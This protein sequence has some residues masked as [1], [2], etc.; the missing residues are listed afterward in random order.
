MEGDAR[1]GERQQGAR[2]RACAQLFDEL[3]V[4]SDVVSF[5]RKDRALPLPIQNESPS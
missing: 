1:E 3:S 4:N 5:Q 2:C